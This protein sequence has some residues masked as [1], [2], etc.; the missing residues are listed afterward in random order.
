MRIL[1]GLLCGKTI[2]YILFL[3]YLKGFI[4]LLLFHSGPSLGSLYNTSD[5][6]CLDFYA[7]DD[8]A[9]YILPERPYRMEHQI[10]RFCRRRYFDQGIDKIDQ[11]A[12]ALTF[13]DLHRFNVTGADLLSW[14]AN[15]DIVEEYEAFRS[16]SINNKNFAAHS[17]FYNCSRNGNFGTFCQYSFN[18]KIGVKYL[19][20]CFS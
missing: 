9:T 15:L 13:Y 4:F 20:V 2:H 18:S 7:N 19:K 10:I 1:K 14:S 16:G 3:T 5:D 17:V 8:I 12:T 11:H 6:D